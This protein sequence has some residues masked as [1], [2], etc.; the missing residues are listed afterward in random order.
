MESP[1]SSRFHMAEFKCVSSSFRTLSWRSLIFPHN[2]KQRIP[3]VYTCS[4]TFWPLITPTSCTPSPLLPALLVIFFP[5]VFLNPNPLLS[6]FPLFTPGFSSSP[7]SCTPSATSRIHFPASFLP[8]QPKSLPFPAH[9]P[10]LPH[11]IHPFP[12]IC[13]FSSSFSSLS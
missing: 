6:S 10:F 5:R 11:F 1:L 7:C 4:S 3:S 9:C 13:I 2:P 12:L 8:L